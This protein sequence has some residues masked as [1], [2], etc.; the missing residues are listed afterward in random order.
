MGQV[1]YILARPYLIEGYKHMFFFE[2]KDRFEKAELY[3]N[4]IFPK[5]SQEEEEQ[6]IHGDQRYITAQ[7]A[8][9]FIISF[10]DWPFVE[11]I[12]PIILNA[13]STDN[14][15]ILCIGSPIDS[16]HDDQK[17]EPMRVMTKY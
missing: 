12:E 4:S 15:F 9:D 14:R 1:K 8:A 6:H 5:L 16:G 17:M 11:Y 13:Y 3:L 7:Q 2:D 10:W